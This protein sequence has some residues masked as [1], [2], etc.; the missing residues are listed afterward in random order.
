MIKETEQIHKTTNNV[1]FLHENDCDIQRRSFKNENSDEDQKITAIDEQTLTKSVNNITYWLLLKNLF[2]NVLTSCM[3]E[4]L[5]L[6]ENHFTGQIKDSYL[7]NGVFL[8]QNYLYL[9]VY[10]ICSGFVEGMAF[11]CAKSFGSKNDYLLGLQ[12]NQTRVLIL[13]LFLILSIFTVFFSLPVLNLISGCEKIISVAHRYILFMIP[14]QFCA[15]NYEIYSKYSETQ[16]IYRPQIYALIFALTIHPILCYVFIIKLQ[17]G[18]TGQALSSSIV[19]I[20]KVLIM[21]FYYTIKNPFPKSNFCFNKDT[22]VG[23]VK[24]LKVTQFTAIL[25]YFENAGSSIM[26][27]IASYLDE[28]DNTKYVVITCLA[29]ISYALGYGFLNTGNIIVG[30]YIG[31]NSSINAKK[32]IIYLTV[33]SVITSISFFAICITFPK[34]LCYFFF[35]SESVYDSKDMF[36]NVL[37]MGVGE[38]FDIIQSTLQGC[39][40]GLGVLHST[41][42]LGFIAYFLCQPGIAYILGIYF[43]LGVFGFLLSPLIVYCGLTIIF[44]FKLFYSDFDGICNSFE[45]NLQKEEIIKRNNE[46]IDQ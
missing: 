16:L 33:L 45:T 31:S 11:L 22:F 20:C 1:P 19:E 41:A 29:A 9:V 4:A 10:Y 13:I 2:P 46:Q 44:G 32:S 38:I 5:V 39:L 25:Y 17:L 23:F 42:L 36:F 37:I 24:L 30:N 8:G 26:G 14:G 3:Y 35:E 34:Q 28:I 18:E 43:K 21:F 27:V 6:I 12:T 7:I 40:L 15:L